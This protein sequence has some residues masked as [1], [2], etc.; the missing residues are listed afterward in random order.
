MKDTGRTI[1]RVE[2]FATSL[3]YCLPNTVLILWLLVLYSF[4]RYHDQH[5][6]LRPAARAPPP[7]YDLSTLYLQHFC[8]PRLNTVC[9]TSCYLYGAGA[10]E[11][12]ISRVDDDCWAWFLPFVNDPDVDPHNREC[13]GTHDSGRACPD[14]QDINVTFQRHN[15]SVGSWERVLSFLYAAGP[16]T[17]P[18][19]CPHREM[20]SPSDNRRCANEAGSEGAL[21]GVW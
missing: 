8:H 20:P 3:Q 11:R 6:P 16:L 18:R 10:N 1:C 2:S 17:S 4:V 21:Y 15:E 13:V 12:P 5:L 9:L 7:A 19:S 14:D